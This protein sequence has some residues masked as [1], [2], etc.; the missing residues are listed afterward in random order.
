MTCT[1]SQTYRNGAHLPE[2]LTR[3]EKSNDLFN[4]TENLSEPGKQ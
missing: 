4:A 3:E 1:T 2:L